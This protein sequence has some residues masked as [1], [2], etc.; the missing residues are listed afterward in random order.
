MQVDYT[1][2][3]GFR[4]LVFIDNGLAAGMGLYVTSAILYCFRICLI[5]IE[6]RRLILFS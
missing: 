1:A 3:F 4:L 6:F 2:V 5:I